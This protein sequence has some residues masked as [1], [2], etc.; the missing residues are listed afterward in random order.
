MTVSRLFALIALP[1]GGLLSSSTAHAESPDAPTWTAF[2]GTG[3][4][5]H[6]ETHDFG[7]AVTLPLFGLHVQYIASARWVGELGGHSLLGLDSMGWDALVRGGYALGLHGPHQSSGEATR[8]FAVPLLGYRYAMRPVSHSSD[9]YGPHNQTHSAQL[10]VAYDLFVGAGTAFTLRLFGA[11]EY[12]FVSKERPSAFEWS[13]TTQ[14]PM[15][16]SVQ[17]GLSLGVAFGGEN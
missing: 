2:R 11:F 6:W 3:L 14:E 17:G 4:F 5:L 7:A 12:A 10:G 8:G 1:L 15:R 13:Y 9:G 16:T